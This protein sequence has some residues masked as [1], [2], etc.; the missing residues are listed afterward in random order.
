MNRANDQKKRGYIKRAMRILLFTCLLA[1][2]M[3]YGQAGGEQ[4]MKGSTRISGMSENP[5]TPLMYETSIRSLAEYQ[6]SEHLLPI[7]KADVKQVVVA[8]SIEKPIQTEWEKINRQAT[9]KKEA[10]PGVS[11]SK[12]LKTTNGFVYNPNIPMPKKHQEYLYKLCQER[13][14]NYKIALAVI[15]HES[16][17][18]PNEISE[19]DDYGYFQV[20]IINHEDLASQLNTPNKP[21]DPII[22]LNWGTS[23]LSYLYSYWKER[24]VSGDQL[25]TYVWSSYNRGIKGFKDN[26]VAVK[27]VKSVRTSLDEIQTIL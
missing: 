19:T 21:L 5:K 14:L 15:K 6:P 27:Y 12:D 9:V 13:G 11:S 2:A 25:D 22:N 16:G 4:E 8:A 1:G 7:K 17:F 26:G 18:D 20:N 24:G 3:V 10:K 23:K